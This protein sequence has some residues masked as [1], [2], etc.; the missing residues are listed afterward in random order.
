MFLL[1]G[2]II[3]PQDQ[4]ESSVKSIQHQL[5]LLIQHQTLIGA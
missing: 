4:M 1:F 3:L 2:I 5:Q